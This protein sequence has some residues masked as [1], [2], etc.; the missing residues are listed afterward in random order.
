[1][2]ALERPSRRKACAS[3]ANSAE[4]SKLRI[5]ARGDSG[6]GRGARGCKCANIQ[7]ES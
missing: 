7:P 5:A 1:L 6:G 2:Y 3:H 4:T